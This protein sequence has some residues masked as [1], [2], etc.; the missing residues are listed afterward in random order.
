MLT[1]FFPAVLALLLLPSCT[2]STPGL[3]PFPVWRPQVTGSEVSLSG[4][5]AASVTI[6]WRTGQAPFTV[7][8]E[9]PSDFEQLPLITTSERTVT[10]DDIAFLVP[11]GTSG[12][13]TYTV[14]FRIRDD[15]G[16]VTEQTMDVDFNFAAL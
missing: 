4:P 14:T 3:L 12:L 5:R 15:L 13:K 1:R 11:Q 7:D 2:T 9:M 8:I 6:D 16:Q 10:V